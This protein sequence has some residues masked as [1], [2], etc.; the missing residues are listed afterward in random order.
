MTTIFL[1]INEEIHIIKSLTYNTTTKSYKID[2]EKLETWEKVT[3]SCPSESTNFAFTEGLFKNPPP[4]KIGSMYHAIWL[5]NT[6]LKEPNR[7]HSKS[8]WWQQ[9][10]LESRHSLQVD[11]TFPARRTTIFISTIFWIP[12]G[13]PL[14]V[15]LRVTENLLAIILIPRTVRTEEF[16]NLFVTLKISRTLDKRE[17]QSLD[18][19]L[20]YMDKN[21]GRFIE[22]SHINNLHA[23]VD[24]YGIWIE[25]QVPLAAPCYE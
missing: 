10:T 2:T 8:T 15:R 3:I 19:L 20:V 21:L 7:N 5:F 17:N 12:D 24:L 18:D 11:T 13:S 1:D 9:D 14:Q 4:T 22:V 23:L 25:H 16:A 6:M